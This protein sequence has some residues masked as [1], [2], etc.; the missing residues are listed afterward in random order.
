MQGSGVP[1]CDRVSVAMAALRAVLSE[2]SEGPLEHQTSLG[3]WG[4]L[5]EWC[6]LAASSTVLLWNKKKK[7]G[8]TF[9]PC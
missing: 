1:V 4:R 6:G 3:N 8:S 5:C 9:P 7:P 2:G